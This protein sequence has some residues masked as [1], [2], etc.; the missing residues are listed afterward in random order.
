M[1]GALE[2]VGIDTLGHAQRDE[3]SADRVAADQQVAGEAFVL[4]F[5]LI[6]VHRENLRCFRDG[7]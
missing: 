2:V 1:A 5:M 4:F 3:E 6:A 7:S